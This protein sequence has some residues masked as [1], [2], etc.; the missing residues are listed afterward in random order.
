MGYIVDLSEHNTVTDWAAAAKD[1][2][3]AIIRIGYRGS[4]EGRAAYKKITEDGKFHSH[5]AGCQKYGIPYAVYYFPTPVSDAEAEEEAAWLVTRIRGLDLCMPVFIDSENVQTDRSGRADKLSRKD[6][7]RLLKIITAHLLGQGIPCGIYSY[8]SWLQNNVDLSALDPRVVKNTWVAQT[9]K[10]TYKGA[11]VIWQYGKKK[12][13]WTTA[14]VDV[15]KIMG[16]FDMT[17]QKKEEKMEYYRQTIVEKARSFLGTKTGSAAHREILKAYNAIRPLPR[18]VTMTASMPWCATFVSAVGA[19]CGYGAVIPAE[20]SCGYMVDAAKKLG[21]WQERD[22]YIPQPGD[23]LMYD[24]DDNKTGSGDCTGWPDHT[25]F[26]ETVEKGSFTTIEGNSG[27]GNGEVKRVKVQVDQ[28]NIRG[29]ITPRYTADAQVRKP[30][31]RTVQL[32]LT[33]PEIHLGD[34]GEHVRLWQWLI[35]IEQ[36]SIFDEAAQAETMKWQKANGKKVDGWI[37]KGCWT[38]AMQVKEWR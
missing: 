5:L 22:D 31:V 14:P 28:K 30:E 27:S 37:G 19:M 10:L 3:A 34:R 25:G 21:I 38:K 18:G 1:L 16:T 35:G 2:D 24:W 26:V 20:C 36:T 11:C 13:P 17:V 32:T 23:I 8:T 15:D 6:R 4:I 9:P 29:F 12:F 7:T 33:L